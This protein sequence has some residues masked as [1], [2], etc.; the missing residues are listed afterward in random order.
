MKFVMHSDQRMLADVSKVDDLITLATDMTGGNILISGAS[1]VLHATDAFTHGYCLS[2]GNLGRGP[3]GVPSAI[4]A[5]SW[6]AS[7]I[8]FAPV[9]SSCRLRSGIFVTAV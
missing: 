8:A 4:S 9:R 7:W 3:D 1:M 2:A 5:A 6:R